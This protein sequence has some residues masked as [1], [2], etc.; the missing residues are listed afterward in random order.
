MLKKIKIFSYILISLCLSLLLI[1]K[2][3]LDGVEG[4]IFSTLL[5]E[6][7]VY[8]PAYSDK[9]FKKIHQNMRMK[10]VIELI[11][12]P[13]FKQTEFFEEYKSNIDRWWY[14]KS[15]SS[16]HYRIREIRFKDGKVCEKIHYFW[17]D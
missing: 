7:T 17:G 6:D 3:S 4:L 10:D 16:S 5:K 1:N 13:L 8:A 15:A 12:N 14:S 2:F 11:G 9:G